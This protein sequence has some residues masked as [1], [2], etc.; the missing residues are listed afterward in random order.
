LGANLD[1]DNGEGVGVEGVLAGVAVGAGFSFGGFRAGGL[2]VFARL[3]A[4]RLGW[5]PSVE[6]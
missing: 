4:T 5:L 6:I 1:A 2:R 3:A